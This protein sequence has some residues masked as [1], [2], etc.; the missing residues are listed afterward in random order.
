LSVRTRLT[1]WYTAALAG[2]LA[3]LGAA[4]LF[5]LDRGLRANIDATLESLAQAVAQ[6]SRQAS[7]FGPDVDAALDALLGPSLTRR[8]F[9]LLDPSGR[10]DPRIVSRT[11]LPLSVD[12]VRNA[13]RGRATFESVRLETTPPVPVRVLT[14]PV[15]DRGRMAHLVQVALP[16]DSVETARRRFLFILLGLAPIALAAAASGGWLLAGRAL[17]PVDSMVA[18]ARRI[19]AEGL[20]QRLAGATADDEIGRLAAVLNDMLGRLERSFT[21]VSQFSA[22]AAHELRTPL[23]ILKGEIEVAL[24]GT[25]SVAEYQGVLA[26]CLEE[27]DRLTALV[28][29]LLFLARADAGGMQLNEHV[30]LASVIADVRP[31]LEALA[32]RAH[33]TLNAETAE[34]LVVRG[35]APMLFR[36]V[37]NLG[38]NA[39]KYCSAGN[40]IDITLTRR[41]GHA[42]ISVRDNGPGI[43]ADQLP[44]IF[45]RFYRG[46]PARV[47]GGTGL[48][49]ALTKSIIDVHGGTIRVDSTV[50]GGTAFT[51]SLPVAPS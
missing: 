37:F 42:Q 32:D 33:V 51:I 34:T 47:R 39:I 15:L 23:T 11:R 46:D 21:M 8:F 16:L 50:G 22:D 35:S 48:G 40:R 12:A 44:H 9:Q 24:S 27:V 28:E 4:A 45:D 17:A 1:L 18:A 30:D 41:N 26:S 49:L 31:A 2:L 5:L 14:Q 20:S 25:P 13:E 7:G 19:S 38:D 43:P 36:A 6:S 3:L 10:P 29:D